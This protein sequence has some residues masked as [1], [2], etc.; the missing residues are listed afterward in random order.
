M[1]MFGG[2]GFGNPVGRGGSDP[3]QSM[4]REQSLGRR[5]QAFANPF[6]DLASTYTPGTVRDLFA[7]C[8][9]YFLTH[10]LI[11]AIC[12]KSAEYPITDLILQSPSNGIVSQWQD[13]MLGTLNYRVFQLE[14]NLDYFVFGNAFISPTFPFHKMLRCGS[15]PAEMR[16]ESS[17][18]HWRFLG[19]KFWL[20]CPKCGQSGEAKARDDYYPKSA[21]IGL[22]RWNPRDVSLSYNEA[23]GQTTYM[24]TIPARLS[25]QVQMGQKDIIASTPQVF[26]EAIRLKKN[27]VFDKNSVFHMRRPGPSSIERGWGYPLLM[28]VLKDAFYMQIMKKSQESVLLTHLEPQVFLYPQPATGGADPFTTT[29]LADW[30]GHLRRELA[31]Q[32]IDPSYYGILPFPLGHQTIG[33][34]GRSLLLMPEIQQL[35]EQIMVGMGF[36]PDLLLGQG[37]YAGNS[38]S[39]RMLENFFLG[40]VSAHYR[41]AAW[42]TQRIGAFLNWEVPTIKFKPFRMADDLQRQALLLQYNAAG[43]ISDTTLLSLSDIKPEDEA[44]LIAKEASALKEAAMSQQLVQAEIQGKAG[45]VQAKYQAK[46]QSAMDTAT[47]QTSMVRDPWAQAMQS[48]LSGAPGGISLDAVAAAFANKIRSMPPERREAYLRQINAEAPELTA[49]QQFTPQEGQPQGGDPG[50]NP[51]DMRPMPEQLPPR[52]AGV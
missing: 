40:N 29:S 21:D 22:M 14:V 34:H 52:R 4:S 30:R 49:N 32:R 7:Y 38:V 3:A 23:T 45:V 27:L 50:Q 36:P 25:A 6:F 2:P 10:G 48:D 12:T 39:M 42:V 47:Q 15:C 35:G 44:K 13:L 16:A 8:Q 46:A 41:L 20:T 11:N 5:Y 9:H 51:V 28:P 1:S 37:T 19:Q 24:L 31:R 18:E 17:R 43:K 33:E 26:L